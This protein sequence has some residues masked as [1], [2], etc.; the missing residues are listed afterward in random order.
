MTVVPKDWSPDSRDRRF[1]LWIGAARPVGR[2]SGR[3]FCHVKAGRDAASRTKA[4]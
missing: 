4:A 2:P 1:G 3:D